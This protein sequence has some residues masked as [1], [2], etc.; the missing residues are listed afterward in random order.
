[1]WELIG[2]VVSLLVVTTALTFLIRFLR[3][4]PDLLFD[5]IF[6]RRHNRYEP[7]PNQTG[8]APSAMPDPRTYVPD[9]P[10]ERK[11][12]LLTIPE[13]SFFNLLSTAVS[14][15]VYICP[16][17]CFGGVLNVTATAREYQSF[18]NRVQAKRID[19]L[20]CDKRTLTPLV[21]VEL[22]NSSHD[23]PNRIERDDFVD[24]ACASA[25]LAILHFRVRKYYDRQEIGRILQSTISQAR[26]SL[27]VAGKSPV[28]I[29]PEFPEDQP[30]E[31]TSDGPHN[32]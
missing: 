2:I 16:Q 11:R 28:A 8:T 24:E 30:A 14:D 12:Y 31:R 6:S 21:A 7:V 20:L 26:T 19:F 5:L 18:W 1:M 25:G 15:D 27:G 3:S 29:P 22:D 13:K 32:G 9:L 10:Y 17:V 4:I 23:S